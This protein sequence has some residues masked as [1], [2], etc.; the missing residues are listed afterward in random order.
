ML[1]LLD[2]AIRANE[3][4]AFDRDDLDEVTGDI[5]IRD[6]KGGK[7]RLVVIGKKTCKAVRAY[8]R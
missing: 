3:L 7:T 2:T 8:L 1:T 6:G 5:H 4:C